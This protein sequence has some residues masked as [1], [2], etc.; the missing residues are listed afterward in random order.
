MAFYL[1]G[2]TLVAPIGALFQ[3]FLVNAIGP[4]AA[5]TFAGAA[6]LSLLAL[7]RSRGSLRHLDAESALVPAS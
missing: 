2:V 6:F 4:R 3:G 1:L 5:F 7:L